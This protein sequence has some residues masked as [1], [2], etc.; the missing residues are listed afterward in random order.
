VVAIGRLV[1]VKNFQRLIGILARVHEK[2]PE[3]ETIIVGEGRE[4]SSLQARLADLGAHSYVS[5][6]GRLG[7]EELLDLYR[8]AW[9][10]ASTSTREGWGLT[11]SEAAACATPAVATRIPGHV[12]AIDDG[13]TGMLVETDADFEL[14]FESLL[15]DALLRRRLGRAASEHVAAL[16]WETTAKGALAALAAETKRRARLR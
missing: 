5:L 10:V 9:V 2:I 8:R 3:L 1:P 11:L 4:R 14:Q 15:G 6:P 13:V 7:A 12:D 16:T